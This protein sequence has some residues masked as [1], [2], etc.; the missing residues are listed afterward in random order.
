[1]LTKMDDASIARPG[2]TDGTRHAVWND[3]LDAARMSRYAERMESRYRTLH[4]TVR[5]LLLLSASG[6][7][8]TI[9]GMIPEGWPGQ[10]PNLAVAVLIA[11]DFMSDYATKIA[12]LNSTKRECQDLET[13]WRRL[14]LDVDSATADDAAVRERN[15]ELSSRLGRATIP[16]DV[17][18]K[19]SEQVNTAST[20]DAYRTMEQRY[21]A[22]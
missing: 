8:A 3:L 5:F 22:R 6:S 17:H 7:V 13:E 15:R 2:V 16:M 10:L 1:M 19:V 9:V 4:W 21:A 11:W 20:A 12:V 18:V 14:W